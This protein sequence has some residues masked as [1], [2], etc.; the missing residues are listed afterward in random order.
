VERIRIKKGILLRE[1]IRS[2][3]KEE[4]AHCKDQDST[5]DD[6]DEVLL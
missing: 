4:H 3:T 6:F 5:E 1:D 2:W